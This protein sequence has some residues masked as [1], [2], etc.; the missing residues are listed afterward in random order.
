MANNEAA[1]KLNI[2]L[3]LCVVLVI[4][5]GFWSADTLAVSTG[6]DLGYAF[7]DS[8]LHKADGQPIMSVYDIFQCQNQHYLTTN[9][10][11]IVHFI[12]QA[13]VSLIPRWMFFIANSLL[14]ILLWSV[15][16]KLITGKWLPD[17]GRGIAIAILIWLSVP[18]PGVVMLSLVAFAVN[19]LWTGALTLVFLYLIEKQCRKKSNP[20]IFEGIGWV[21]FSALTG[22]LQESFSLPV[23]GAIFVAIIA[24]KLPHRGIPLMMS[25]GYWCGTLACVLAP[26]NLVRF[27]SPDG[28][29]GIGMGERLLSLG[30]E[31]AISIPSLLFLL[32]L[33]LVIFRNRVIR[34]FIKENFIFLWS[35]V[36]SLLMCSIVYSAERQLTGLCLFSMIMLG[37]LIK[38]FRLDRLLCKRWVGCTFLFLY[39]VIAVGVYAARIPG[40]YRMY[41]IED[42]VREGKKTAYAPYIDKYS[43]MKLLLIASELLHRYTCDPTEGA[44][45]KIVGD[46]YT[47]RGLSRLYSPSKDKKAVTALLPVPPAEIMTV[48]RRSQIL[49]SINIKAIQLTLPGCS[50]AQYVCFAVPRKQGRK[51]SFSLRDN[52]CPPYEHF[53]ANDTLW[54]ILATSKTDFK[55][56]Y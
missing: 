7:T 12:V 24:R 34:G 13:F 35:A 52:H 25:L 39:S 32:L 55:Y 17:A 29:G 53:L 49:D 41:Q 27:T 9:G 51:F 37:R 40:R 26:G 43:E 5:L 14:F 18:R 15:S 54:Y 44:A 10:R 4:F 1:T 28:A 11:Y 8:K 45:L 50:D 38:E 47:R 31:L 2:A 56:K 42:C 16:C 46:G 23:S 20:R 22:S 48:A 33:L 30:K 21:V 6:D 36:F 3:S 19:Y